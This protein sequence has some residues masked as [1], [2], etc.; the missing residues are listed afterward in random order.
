MLGYDTAIFLGFSRISFP[1]REISI[2]IVTGRRLRYFTLDVAD[3]CR[4]S[5]LLSESGFL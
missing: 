5:R 2:I 1:F 3:R 4:T